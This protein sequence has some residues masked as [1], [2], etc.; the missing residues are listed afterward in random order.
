M[1]YFHIALYNFDILLFVVY[2]L[3]WD[4]RLKVTFTYD[5]LVLGFNH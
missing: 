5:D 3:T 4:V 2:D 1:I